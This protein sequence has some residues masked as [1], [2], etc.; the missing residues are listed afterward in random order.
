MARTRD[1]TKIIHAELAADPELAEAVEFESINADIA[2]KVYEARTAAGLSQKK[3]AE[4]VGTQ[5][6]VISRIEDADYD[7]HSLNLLRR[8]ARVLGKRLRIEFYDGTPVS[9]EVVATFSPAWEIQQRWG[10]GWGDVWLHE[11]TSIPQITKYPEK[12]AVLPTRTDFLSALNA[13]TESGE[14]AKVHRRSRFCQ[15]GR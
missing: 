1:F 10:E 15:H 7:G 14:P 3:L 8:I 2:A 11:A 12:M 4:L 13:L 6:S 9:E 5:Q